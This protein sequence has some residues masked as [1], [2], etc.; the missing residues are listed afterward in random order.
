[1]MEFG[2]HRLHKDIDRIRDIGG[3]A[4]KWHDWTVHAQTFL[5]LGR[6]QMIMTSLSDVSVLC[7]HN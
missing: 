7:I 2:V 1:M 3:C 4:D 5:L 6:K